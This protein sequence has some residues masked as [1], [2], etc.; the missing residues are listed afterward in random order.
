M[1][2]EMREKLSIKSRLDYIV[3]VLSYGQL[4][5]RRVGKGNHFQL[6]NDSLYNI[7]RELIIELTYPIIGEREGSP[8]LAE[9]YIVRLN[10]A[11]SALLAAAVTSIS[12]KV[13]STKEL[14]KIWSQIRDMNMVNDNNE[15]LIA[16]LAS[17]RLNDLKQ[18]VDSGGSIELIL[19]NYRNLLNSI[20]P[21]SRITKSDLAAAHLT[22][23]LISQSPEIESNAQVIEK[24][25]KLK[26]E[27]ELEDDDLSVTAAILAGG[28]ILN[29]TMKLQI[30]DIKDI[31]TGIKSRLL[32]YS[33]V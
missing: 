31:F 13:E 6:I 10:D 23:A 27:L 1:W 7:K 19:N 22:I 30:S 26:I 2:A 29:R 21:N 24:W 32:D 8:I 28:L 16:L 3:A 25:K 5:D 33:K 14:I 11:A 17:S 20:V 18:V 12:K 4:M 9:S 15:Y